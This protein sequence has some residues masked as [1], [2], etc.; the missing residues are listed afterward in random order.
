MV[1]IIK[2]ILIFILLTTSLLAQSN[3]NI[4]QKNDELKGIKSKILKLE[5]DLK[6]KAADEVKSVKLLDKINHQTHLLDKIIKKLDSDERGIQKR[7]KKLK[8]EII[9]IKNNVDELKEDYSNFVKWLYINGEKSKWNYLFKSESVNQAVIRYKYFNYITKKN[10]LNIESFVRE[11]EKLE[12]LSQSL[13]GENREKQKLETEKLTEVTR[14]N[15][16]KKEKTNLIS[17][18]HKDKRNIEKEIDEKR[19]YEIEIKER[20]AKLIEEARVSKRKLRETRFK[21]NSTESIVPKINYAKFEKFS[22]L[23]GKMAWP[24]SSGKVVRKF[25]EIKNKKLKTITLNYGIDIKSNP[26]EKV[27]AVAEGVVSVIDWIVGFGS[28]IIVTHNGN[29]R[30]VYGHIDNIKVNEDEIVKAGTELGTINQSLEGNIVH[31]EIWD[32]RNYKN[33]QKWLVKK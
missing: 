10:E 26:N 19:K 31:F 22:D 5:N 15:N 17:K 32:E 16:R 30:T 8:S 4:E 28:I 23:K 24:V 13:M 18:L 25:G 14:L 11:K 27:Y 21:N 29:F 33:P 12:K 20:I 1:T 9:K 3:K 7:I 6:S 2:H